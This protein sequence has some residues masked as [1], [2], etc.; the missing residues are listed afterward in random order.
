MVYSSFGLFIPIHH[1]RTQPTHA[2]KEADMR[3]LVRVT[4]PIEPFNTFVKEG[5]V[6]AKMMRILY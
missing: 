2:L 5:S 3:I 4:F 1:E 6:S